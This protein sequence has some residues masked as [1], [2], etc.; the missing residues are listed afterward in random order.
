[1]A[2]TSASEEAVPLADEIE[3]TEET[4]Q[5]GDTPPDDSL[6]G[7]MADNTSKDVAALGCDFDEA[8]A[9][10]VNGKDVMFFVMN[11]AGDD[12]LAVAGQQSATWS[13]EVETSETSIKSK[14]GGWAV[15]TPG[16]KS[17]SCSHEGLGCVDDEA[18]QSIAKCINQGRAL[19]VGLYEQEITDAGTKYTPIRRG[20]AIPTSN[21]LD[22]PA[23]DNMTISVSFEGTGPCWM[24]ETA[25]AEEVAKHT[26]VVPAN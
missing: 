25:T 12:I 8:T 3:E 2:K 18:Q 17:W 1:M 4:D 26:F 6:G 14:D 16:G 24:R 19:C 22:A 10:A 13:I 11:S 5:G 9:Q 23:D 21:E 15:K 7:E 20:K